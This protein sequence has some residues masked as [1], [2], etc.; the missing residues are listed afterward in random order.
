MANSVNRW[1]FSTN[2]KDI[3]TL[4]IIFGVISGIIGTTLSVLICMEIS[5]SGHS[6]IR[7]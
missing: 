3:G 2:H 1:F 4:Y 5:R 7:R 6:S